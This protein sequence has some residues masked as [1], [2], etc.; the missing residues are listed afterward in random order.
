MS[1]V[2]TRQIFLTV[3]SDIETR[4][5]KPKYPTLIRELDDLIWGLHRKELLVIGARPSHGKTS[6]QLNIAWNLAKQGVP[7]I[8]VSLEMSREAIIERIMCIEYGV[9]GWQLRKG[10]QAAIAKAK[11]CAPEFEALL[12][13]VPLEIIDYKGK[14][15][16]QIQEI[17][18]EF[19][20]VFIFIDHAQ[21]ISQSGYGNKYEALSDYVNTLQSL[22]IKHDIGIVLNSQIN[23]QG[24]QEK[25]ATDYFKGSGEIEESADTLLQCKW[26][27]RDNPNHVDPKEYHISVLK[28]RHGACD[29]STIDFD[30]GTFKF[31]SR[32]DK[33][34]KSDNPSIRMAGEVFLSKAL[35]TADR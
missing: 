1:H 32:L 4:T 6:L 35:T 34:E 24:S 20:P 10:Y 5:G 16:K 28:Q 26:V 19:D 31:D 15:I 11:A 30:A 2:G 8:F 14:T 27:L 17:I 25:N 3:L 12:D 23:R 7:C 13:S 29:Y 18:D 33:V 22:A 9:N 21:K